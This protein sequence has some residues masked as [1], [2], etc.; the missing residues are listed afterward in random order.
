[1]RLVPGPPGTGRSF[2]LYPSRCRRWFC[3]VLTRTLRKCGGLRTRP[4]NYASNSNS[5]LK[6]NLPMP[7]KNYVSGFGEKDPDAAEFLKPD[8]SPWDA[9]ASGHQYTARYRD[10]SGASR[11]SIHA[12]SDGHGLVN[13][14]PEEAG[15]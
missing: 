10:D 5:K 8:R 13:T 2:T 3:D 7:K 15:A 6:R 4:L 11:G 9:E 12:D 14:L 1:M